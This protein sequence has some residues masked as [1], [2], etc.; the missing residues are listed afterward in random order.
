MPHHV[1]HTW[2]SILDG[3]SRVIRRVKIVLR[4]HKRLPQSVF[5]LSI[6]LCFFLFQTL[7]VPKSH[8]QVCMQDLVACARMHAHSRSDSHAC[9][10]TN[11]VCS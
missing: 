3:E 4:D 9:T 10:Y 2:L 1:S 7:D 11:S 8:A 6:I 5:G